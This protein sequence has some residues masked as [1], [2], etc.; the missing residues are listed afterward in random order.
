[1]PKNDILLIHFGI[2]SRK[3]LLCAFS[4][5]A[6]LI[7]ILKPTNRPIIQPA[8]SPL[9][10]I[11]NINVDASDSLDGTEDVSHGSVQGE[12]TLTRGKVVKGRHTF[13]AAV[14]L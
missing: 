4:I 6:K 2:P 13:L 11:N 9:N 5:P 1:M 14:Q 10:Q 8:S 12:T 3:E 7:K